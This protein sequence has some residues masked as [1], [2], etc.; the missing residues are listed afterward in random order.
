[1]S[2]QDQS[3]TNLSLNTLDYNFVSIVRKVFHYI[4]NSKLQGPLYNE[5]WTVVFS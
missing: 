4:M 1:M 2:V 5:Y 3:G